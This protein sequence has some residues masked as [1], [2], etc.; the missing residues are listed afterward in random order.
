MSTSLR[1]PGSDTLR[2]CGAPPPMISASG[3]SAQSLSAAMA[4]SLAIFSQL[5]FMP[6]KAI[7]AALPK[8]AI[9]GMASV[10]ARIPLS[11]APPRM[12]GL[13]LTP[14]LIYNAPMPFGA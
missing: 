12:R 9:C 7:S 4:R 13:I 2:M 14:V 5:S 1:Q 10:P 6:A 3:I 11:W 8:A